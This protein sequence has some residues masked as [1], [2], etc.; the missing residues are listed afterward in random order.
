MGWPSAVPHAR[1][2][3]EV[4]IGAVVVAVAETNVRTYVQGADGTNGVGFFSL[5]AARLGAVL[6]ARTTYRLPYFWSKMSV[7]RSGSTMHYK[8]ERRWPGPEASSHATIEIG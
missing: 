8:C 7:E 2:S 1:R 5:D 6:V 3:A 4:A